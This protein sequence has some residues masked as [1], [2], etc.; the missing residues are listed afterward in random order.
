M[1][2]VPFSL[3]EHAKVIVGGP[4]MGHAAVRLDAP[5]TKGTSGLTLLCFSPP[6]G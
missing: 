3:P 2:V 4:M 6:C 5:V 1:A